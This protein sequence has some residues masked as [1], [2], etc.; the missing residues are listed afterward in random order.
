MEMQ[1][2]TI[3]LLATDPF[4]KSGDAHTTT[5][6]STSTAFF[7]FEFPFTLPQFSIS[8]TLT[9]A[10]SIATPVEIWLIGDLKD[11]AIT[12]TAGGVAQTLTCTKDMVATDQFKITTGF[13]N[14]TATFYATGVAGVN[15]FQWIDDDSVFFQL[16]PGENQ[17]SIA[18]TTFAAAASVTIAWYDRW[19]GE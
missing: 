17:I 18:Y 2:A 3:D 10:G 9:N 19:I 11:V 15:G 12:R 4:W 14:K 16:E 8:G 7:P 13:G 1:R 5:F 6:T